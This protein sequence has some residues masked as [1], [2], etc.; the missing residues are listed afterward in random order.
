VTLAVE[1]VKVALGAL[2][3]LVAAGHLEGLSESELLAATA[4]VQA[5][6]SRA[7]AVAVSMVAEV[8]D[9]DVAKS[10]GFTSTTRFLETRA[11]LSKGESRAQVALGEK[12]AWE[13]EA[14]A[15]AWLAG[16]ITEGAVQVITSLI[17][18]KLK[19]LP[20]AEYYAERTRLEAMA[21]HHARTKTVAEVKRSIERA[22]IVADPAGALDAAVVAKRNEFLSF[23]P[24]EDGVEVRG[25]LSWDTAGVVLPCFDQA[26]DAMYRNG[27]LA[28]DYSDEA[29][30]ERVMSRTPSLRRKR[31]EHRNAQIFAELAT[32]LLD[33]GELGTKHAQRPHLTVTVHADDF[34]AGLGGDILLPGFGPV[35][36]PN[37]TIERF[38]CDAE[39]H[40]VLTRR[41]DAA[42]RSRPASPSGSATGVGGSADRRQFP[43]SVPRSTDPPWRARWGPGPGG[44]GSQR[45]DPMGEDP[46]PGQLEVDTD[47][48]AITEFAADLDDHESWWNRFLGEPSR[49]VLDVGRSRRTAPPKIRRALSI[50]DGGC[51]VP[52]CDA[53]PSRCEA[54]HI[55]YWE[56]HGETS[57]SNMILLCSKHHHLVHEGRWRI[58]R[59]EQLD[60]GHPSYVTLVAPAPRP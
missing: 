26:N 19:G 13:F 3:S 27:Q 15:Q 51:A 59:N 5:I 28:E 32:R 39:V 11:G 17:P 33:D 10:D 43:G 42:P 16:E 9:G 60:P 44:V 24:T 14:T 25:F 55:T 6:A 53:D 1:V 29:D 8:N 35:P 36:V 48:A 31:R 30:L 50:R 49:H 58:Q 45:R 20:E 47:L 4:Q 2:T 21:L 41:P 56:H 52:G 54:H 23:T 18:R 46:T 57:I 37:E 7:G 38:L 40:P 12:L 34:A 22:A